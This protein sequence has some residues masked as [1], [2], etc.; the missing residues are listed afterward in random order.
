M[1]LLSKIWRI[2]P[3]YPWGKVYI[4]G[5]LLLFTLGSFFFSYADFLFTTCYEKEIHIFTFSCFDIFHY[6]SNLLES[7]GDPSSSHLHLMGVSRWPRIVQDFGLGLLSSTYFSG[8]MT[9]FFLFLFWTSPSPR[10]HLWC[11]FFIAFFL[12][13]GLLKNG[14]L[15]YQYRAFSHLRELQVSWFRVSISKYTVNVLWLWE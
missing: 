1:E 9:L 13:Q 6:A 7:G 5:F 4:L 15:I 14:T 12:F 10:S 8:V 2:H 11:S 3:A